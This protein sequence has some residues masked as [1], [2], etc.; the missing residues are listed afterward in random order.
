MKAFLLLAVV[1]IFQPTMQQTCPQDPRVGNPI[2]YA[3][4]FKEQTDQHFDFYNTK[5]TLSLVYQ[6]NIV[7]STT[8]TPTA[9]AVVT[10][11]QQRIAIRITDSN[12]PV[13]SWLYMIDI[14]YDTNGL[15]QQISRQAKI[16]STNVV[17]TDQALIQGFFGDA[18]II[19]ATPGNCCLAKL[20]YINFYYMFSQYYKNGLGATQPACT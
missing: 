12:L 1:A 11:S 17:A 13:R 14:T 19:L 4:L 16:R 7:L 20:E 18:T 2:N 9:P 5:T 8:A 15:V 3:H 10:G 6:Q